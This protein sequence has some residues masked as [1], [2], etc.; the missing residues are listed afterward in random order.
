ME[1]KAC[2]PIGKGAAYTEKLDKMGIPVLLTN[3][4]K[5]RSVTPGLYGCAVHWNISKRQKLL[6][7]TYEKNCCGESG[8]NRRRGR[9]H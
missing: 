6:G 1:V 7:V 2:S 3:R 4:L 8:S 9:V 5:R